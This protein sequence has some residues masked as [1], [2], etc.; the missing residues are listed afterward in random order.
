MVYQNQVLLLENSFKFVS[1]DNTTGFKD[2]FFSFFSKL[3]SFGNDFF[4]SAL[5]LKED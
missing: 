3:D 1:F 5:S 2:F 4:F